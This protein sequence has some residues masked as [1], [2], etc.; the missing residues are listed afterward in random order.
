MNKMFNNLFY[1]KKTG[2]FFTVFFLIFLPIY[3]SIQTGS[4]EFGFSLITFVAFYA[5]PINIIVFFQKPYIKKKLREQEYKE[6]LKFYENNLG[7]K[8]LDEFNECKTDEDYKLWQERNSKYFEIVRD[9]VI[10]EF[11]KNEDKYLLKIKK[12]DNKIEKL[13]KIIE[14]EKSIVKDIMK[15]FPFVKTLKNL[16]NRTR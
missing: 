10:R 7:H 11:E 2:V 6:K 12:I 9:F 5:I 13:Q 14:D 3:S 15:R 8:L 1:H 16:Q 4:S